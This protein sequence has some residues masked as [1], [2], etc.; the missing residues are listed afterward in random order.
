MLPYKIHNCCHT[1]NIIIKPNNLGFYDYFKKDF[2]LLFLQV[3]LQQPV[4]LWLYLVNACH[5]F[6]TNLW[7]R[8]RVRGLQTACLFPKSVNPPISLFISMLNVTSVICSWTFLFFPLYLLTHS[9]VCVVVHLLPRPLSSA[10]VADLEFSSNLSQYVNEQVL[11][12]VLCSLMSCQPE[13][14]LI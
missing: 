3:D 1:K 11:G 12:A 5:H 14:R 13:A 4:Q 8:R 9:S 2:E 10:N 7:C 6:W